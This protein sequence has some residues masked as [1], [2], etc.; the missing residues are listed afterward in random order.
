MLSE[1]RE[2]T[3]FPTAGETYHQAFET[4]DYKYGLGPAGTTGGTVTWSLAEQNYIGR[5]DFDLGLDALA[6]NAVSLLT[7]AFAEWASVANIEFTQVTDSA[8]ADIRF[9]MSYIDGFWNTLA[10]T[11]S[12]VANGEFLYSDIEFDVQESWTPYTGGLTLSFY[13][14][15]LHEIGHA[16]GLS[17]EDDV[18]AVMNSFSESFGY[19][20]NSL[21]ADD[22]AGVQ[23]I[24]GDAQSGTP[25]FGTTS[26]D[27]LTGTTEGEVIEALA[28]DDLV[29]GGEGADVIWGNEGTDLIYGN[30]SGDVIYGNQQ[31]DRIYGGQDADRIYGGKDADIIYGNM[32]NDAIYGNY[33]NDWLYGGQDQD[34]L[35][36][37]QDNDVLFGNK[38]NDDLY[39]NQG[40]DLLYGGTGEDWFF[41]AS[42]SGDDTIADFDTNLDLVIINN[43]VNNSGITTISDALGN[44]TDTG[45]GVVLDLGSGHSITFAGL[46][47]A[48]LGSDDFFI[49]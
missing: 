8:A 22:I 13:S 3:D 30:Q 43:N 17:H 15:A 2:R 44:L 4:S 41:F 24:Y 42:N 46:T 6:F 16:I 21:Q 11:H 31:N 9:G 48:N 25:I 5:W 20:I 29:R 26:N 35:F 19:T 14:V 37:G 45:G 34:A 10:A 23:S 36:G 49:F 27:T 18:P 47:T 1:G 28:G 39:G 38:G 12:V 40:D 32:Q 33:G 7:Q